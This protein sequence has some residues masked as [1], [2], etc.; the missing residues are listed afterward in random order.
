[1]AELLKFV[2]EYGLA[3]VLA[4]VLL[5]GVAIA[6]RLISRRTAREEDDSGAGAVAL[7]LSQIKADQRELTLRLD[8]AERHI[9]NLTSWSMEQRKQVEDVRVDVATIKADV[10]ATKERIEDL[11]ERMDRQE[12]IIGGQITRV[13]DKLDQLILG[14]RRQ[15]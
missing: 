3:G 1:M 9:A 11:C 4:L 10:R 7:T 8:R 15:A 14:Q 12:Q 2:Q 5:G 6:W 13:E